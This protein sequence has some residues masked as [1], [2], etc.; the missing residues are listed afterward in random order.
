M[1]GNKEKWRGK[2]SGEFYSKVRKLYIPVGRV[3]EEAAGSALR[4]E[5]GVTPE[6]LQPI[7]EEVDR[8]QWEARKVGEAEWGWFKAGVTLGLKEKQRWCYFS[9]CPQ[10]VVHL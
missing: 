5:G 10:N 4:R 8:L 2:T 3:A 9:K 1:Q 7:K 6:T